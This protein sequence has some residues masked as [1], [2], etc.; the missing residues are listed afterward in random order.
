MLSGY[1]GASGQNPNQAKPALQ[2]AGGVYTKLNFIAQNYDSTDSEI[3]IVTA[4]NL[5]AD[6]TN[7]G[8]TITWNEIY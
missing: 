2:T 3:Y 8:G 4:K 1:V 5:T 7:V 6:T